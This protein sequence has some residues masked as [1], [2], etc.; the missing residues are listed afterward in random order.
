[1]PTHPDY[2]VDHTCKVGVRRNDWVMRKN[3]ISKTYFDMFRNAQSEM[4]IMSSYFLPGRLFRRGLKRAVRRGVKIRLILAGKS[5]IAL[6]KYA[7]R[8][9]YSWL[10][11]N[12][13]NI[14][15]YQPT[16]LHGKV[17]TM[18]GMR[19]TIGSYNVNNI[20]AY[21]SIELNLDVENA[22]FADSVKNQFEKIMEKD[23]VE[24]T[25]DG[26]NKTGFFEKSSQYFAYWVVR[27][28]YFIFTFYFKQKE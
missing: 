13:I 19:T 1:M 28:I 21:S 16:I 17:A 6:A 3:H 14:F 25:E 27:I 9:M 18:D 15:E 20:S 2:R 22:D 5:D 11:R 26:F 24:I 12:K 10:L 4:I 23:C 8:Y 7:E